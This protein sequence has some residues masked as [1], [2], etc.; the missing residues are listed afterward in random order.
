M[1]HRK[2]PRSPPVASFRAGGHVAA[3]YV[4]PRAVP[5]QPDLRFRLAGTRRVRLPGGVEALKTIIAN[6][7]ARR[8]AKTTEEE[9]TVHRLPRHSQ[10]GSSRRPRTLPPSV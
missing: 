7:F 9:T 5:Y 1:Q 2:G 8:R 3:R 10:S 6:I 4:E